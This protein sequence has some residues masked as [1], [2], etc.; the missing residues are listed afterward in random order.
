MKNIPLED[1][2]S[3]VI[4]KAQRGLKLSDEALAARAE[5]TPAI[6]TDLKEG[7]WNEK[8]VGQIARALQL[9]PA[10]LLALA[11]KEYL[12][13]PQTL[14]GLLQINAPYEDMTVNSYLVYDPKSR[15]A[16]AFDTGPEASVLL[17]A[18][19][20]A[21]VKIALI[22]LTHTHIDHVVALPDLKK[23]TGAPAWVSA[24]E[25]FPGAAAFA[26]G[27][28]FSLGGLRVATRRTSGHARGGVTFVVS[29]LR[30][31]LAIVG[32]AI[33]AGSMGGGAIS[34]EDALRTNRDSIFTLPDDCILGPGHGPL[35]T[36]GEEKKN[37]PFYPEFQ[38]V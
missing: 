28:E 30:R 3:D 31:P 7:Q 9:A 15:E 37:N 14:E 1:S 5:L 29:G 11:R 36:V 24:E 27:K 13:Q 10:P 17:N 35:T 8:A 18:A 25:E 19:T 20:Q 16:I 12:P 38:R 33:F 22:L 34:Y 26:V 2:F 32:D 6:V 4:G 21:Q 23:A